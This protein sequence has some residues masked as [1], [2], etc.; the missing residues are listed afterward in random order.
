[1]SNCI[2]SNSARMLA[3]CGAV[4]VLSSAAM[5]Q[6]DPIERGVQIVRVNFADGTI[7]IANTTAETIA[8]DGWRLCS[9]DFN[10]ARRY[11]SSGGLNGFS[12]DP[13]QSLTVFT[14]D[15]MP[16][17]FPS[18]VDASD[19][20]GAIAG[21]LDQDAFGLQ[22]FFP[23][24]DGVVRFGDSADI[25]DHIQWNVDGRDMG[26]SEQRTGQAVGQGLWT[27]AGEFIIT[28]TDSVEIE[29]TSAIGELLHGPANY[30][31][32]N[33][34]C[35]ADIDMDG[36]LTIFDFLGFQNKFDGG[37]VSADIDMDGSLTIFDFLAFQNLF[38]AGCP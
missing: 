1:M 14:N 17:G 13:G 10:E 6:V 24:A 18:G 31:V 2:L 33:P 28:Q 11:T 7:E 5:A 30:A 26:T 19:L 16:M 38:D 22:V 25:A 34:V 3:A 36:S 9:H 8:L 29:L 20:G 23:G 37:E 35:R 4:A 15:D 32:T 27:A 12:L 21:P